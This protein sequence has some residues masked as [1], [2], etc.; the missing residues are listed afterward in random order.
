MY[1]IA[2]KIYDNIAVIVAQNK[3]VANREFART[4]KLGEILIWR[5]MDDT[6]WCDGSPDAQKKI[7]FDLNNAAYTGFYFK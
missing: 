7:H 5:A 4:K 3:T 2:Y 1:I 6:G